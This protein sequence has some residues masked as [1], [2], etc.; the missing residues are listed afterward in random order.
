MEVMGG[1]QHSPPRLLVD[2]GAVLLSDQWRAAKLE[3]QRDFICVL[4]VDFLELVLSSW[5]GNGDG[6]SPV[7]PHACP[8]ATINQQDL[9]DAL[10]DAPR[11]PH[12]APQP[13]GMASEGA[14]CLRW[15]L[16]GPLRLREGHFGPGGG[17]GGC[18]DRLRPPPGLPPPRERLLLRDASLRWQLYGGRDFGAGPAPATRT[19]SCATA[20]GGGTGPPPS[21][22]G[23]PGGPPPPQPPTLWV[24]A[25][26]VLPHPP[27]PGG[28]PECCLRVA[29]A[30][31]RLHIDQDA[32]LFLRD[33]VSSFMALMDPPPDP[34]HGSG[35]PPGLE[36]E[37]AEPENPV[38]F[39][40]FRF[41][42]EVPVFLDYHGKRVSMEQG[43][44][45]GILIGLAQLNCCHLRLRRLCHR[46]GLL[47]LSRVLS[48]AVSEWLRDIRCHQLPGLLG[49]VAPV[50]AVLRL[51]RAL[52]ELL[53]LGAPPGGVTR[54]VTALGAASASAAVSVGCSLLRALQALAEALYALVAPPTP[55]RA[56]E[57]SPEPSGNHQQVPTSRD[58]YGLGG[59]QCIPVHPSLGSMGSQYGPV[60]G[61][62][63]PIMVGGG[64]SLPV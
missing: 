22:A 21:C 53:L 58:Q 42:A 32:L 13:P 24:K 12:G 2:D 55:P 54:G 23:T 46:H 9:T 27:P 47:G 52:R 5:K 6:Q 44:L 4:D 36:K 16:P 11:L 8:T 60:W 35:T 57:A 33:Y 10:R 62:L 30:P 59:S 61:P 48:F 1:S 28:V 51:W 43:A 18:R 41:T 45:A 56:L 50:H 7:P 31:L 26:R 39:R 64:L 3:L 19:W 14:P 29:L 63:N 15:L 25:L 37:E 40:E 20:S 49:G 34:P 38:Y 17:S